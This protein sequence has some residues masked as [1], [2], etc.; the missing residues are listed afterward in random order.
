MTVEFAPFIA[1]P[2][3]TVGM[4]VLTIV[5]VYGAEGLSRCDSADHTPSNCLTLVLSGDYLTLSNV[6]GQCRTDDA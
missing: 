2:Y 3:T 6:V 1:D 4:P 5:T